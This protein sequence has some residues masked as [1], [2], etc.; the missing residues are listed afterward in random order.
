[1]M[2]WR[3]AITMVALVGGLGLAVSLQ[4]GDHEYIGAEKCKMCHKVQHGSWLE[5][6]HAKATETAKASTERTFEDSCL[7]CHATNADEAMAGVQCEMCHGAGADYKKMSIMK[8]PEQAKAAG[9]VIPS[10]ETCDGCHDGED[11]RKKVVK[12]EQLDNKEAIH[13]FKNPP[14]E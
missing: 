8:D 7:Q 2:K 13:E 5:T 1:M 14:G 3:V 10:Q 4:A 12:A 9:L 11:H 6:K